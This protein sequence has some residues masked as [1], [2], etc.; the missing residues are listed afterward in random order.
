M[1]FPDESSGILMS[2]DNQTNTGWVKDDYLFEGE[3]LFL[4]SDK[5]LSDDL[6]VGDRVV[7]TIFYETEPP[8][9]PYVVGFRKYVAYTPPKLTEK[10]LQEYQKQKRMDNLVD[11]CSKIFWFL[12]IISIAFCMLL[13]VFIW[14]WSLFV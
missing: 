7:Y 1:A 3:L 11:K 5:C 8:Y 4:E 6:T 9:K 2:W 12:Y 10:E 14:A 13:L